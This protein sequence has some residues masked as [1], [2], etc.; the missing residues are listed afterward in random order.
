MMRWLERDTSTNGD[1]WTLDNDLAT[2]VSL[3]FHKE[4]NRCMVRIGTYRYEMNGRTVSEA[5][6]LTETYLSGLLGSMQSSLTHLR[7]QAIGATSQFRSLAS[8]LPI[9]LIQWLGGVLNHDYDRNRRYCDGQAI[10]DVSR[11]NQAS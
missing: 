8:L 6:Q 10:P 11:C 1:R 2:P 3:S 9:T 4:E 7:D 5:K